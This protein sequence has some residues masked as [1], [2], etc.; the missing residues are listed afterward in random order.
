MLDQ[1]MLY[2]A[3]VNPQCIRTWLLDQESD[4]RV[5]HGIVRYLR[6]QMFPIVEEEVF[7]GWVAVVKKARDEDLF[8]SLVIAISLDEGVR[9]MVEGTWKGSAM[10]LKCIMEYYEARLTSLLESPFDSEN[11]NDIMRSLWGLICSEVTPMYMRSIIRNGTLLPIPMPLSRNA[12]RIRR[13]EMRQ[14]GFENM[15][16]LTSDGLA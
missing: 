11:A 8:W 6:E 9:Q 5:V 7:E 15:M 4:K 14:A 13:Q 16:Q 3:T 2:Q 12:Y 1:F 10:A